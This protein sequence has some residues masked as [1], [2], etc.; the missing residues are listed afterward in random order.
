MTRFHIVI[1]FIS[2][3]YYLYFLN[4]KPETYAML[5]QP[6]TL[7][8]SI[9]LYALTLLR[10]VIGWHFLFEGI[11]KAFTPS[12]SSADFLLAFQLALCRFLSLDCRNP[13]C[14]WCC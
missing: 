2:L 7:S 10:I 5:K 9:K 12:W 6:V 8:E 14:S 1:V 4:L 11:S 3:F 13:V